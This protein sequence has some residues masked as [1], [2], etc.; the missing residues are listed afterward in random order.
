M[1]DSDEQ[2]RRFR[3][4]SLFSGAS[5]EALNSLKSIVVTDVLRPR[6]RLV[7]LQENADTI[8]FIRLA[9]ASST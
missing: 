2:I 8:W 7:C 6:D 1:P 4:C 3:R 5:S 9:K